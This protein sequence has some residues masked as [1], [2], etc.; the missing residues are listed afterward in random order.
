MKQKRKVKQTTHTEIKLNYL[1]RILWSEKGSF[2]VP[3]GR[4]KNYEI[5]KS[6]PGNPRLYVFKEI[7]IACVFY[8]F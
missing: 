7:N 2:K 4:T 3:P 6:V 1:A 8:S 5:R